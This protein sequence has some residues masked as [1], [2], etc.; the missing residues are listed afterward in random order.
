MTFEE[1]EY[2]LFMKEK[3]V[4]RASDLPHAGHAKHMIANSEIYATEFRGAFPPGTEVW[5]NEQREFYGTTVGGKRIY[6]GDEL[7]VEVEKV[8]GKEG[9]AGLWSAVDVV[10]KTEGEQN[11]R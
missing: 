5:E 2:Y 3:M 8:N 1:R 6:T 9:S 11:P 7:T 10:R 4:D